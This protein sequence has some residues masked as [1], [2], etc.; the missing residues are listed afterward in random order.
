MHCVVLW[1]RRKNGVEKDLEKLA[2]SESDFMYDNPIW[3]ADSR[4]VGQES[5]L[6]NL[7]PD[8]SKALLPSASH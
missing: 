4:L 7:N 2:E 1:H 3:E 8:Y 5:L 6:R